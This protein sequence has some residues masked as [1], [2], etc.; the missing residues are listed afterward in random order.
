MKTLMAN[1]TATPGFAFA[2]ALDVGAVPEPS[3]PPAARRRR[4][5]IEWNLDKSMA[6]YKDRFADASDFTFV[7]VGSFDLPTMKPLVERYLG[8]LPS[9]HRQGDVEGRRRQAADR[10]HPED[11]REGHRAEEPGGDRLHRAVRIQPDAAR[12]DPRDGRDAAD[13]GCS[14]PIREDLGGTYSITASAELPEDPERPSTR[15][16]IEFGCDP[17]R[18]DD[19][20]KRVFEGDREVQDQRSDREAAERRA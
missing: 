2:E 1:Q 5:S 18:I 11:R 13:R 17:K 12:R 7:F 16:A 14:R 3:A 10:R 20:V 15:S 8:G 4:R 6:F 9:T 19:L